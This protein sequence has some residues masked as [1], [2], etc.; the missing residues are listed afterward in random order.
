MYSSIQ[1][2][3]QIKDTAPSYGYFCICKI[4]KCK[5]HFKL[6]KGNLNQKKIIGGEYFSLCAAKAQEENILI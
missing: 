2:S 6:G 3:D 5:N 1:V 4:W